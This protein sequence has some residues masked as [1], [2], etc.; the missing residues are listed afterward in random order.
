MQEW[1]GALTTGIGMGSVWG[2]WHVP[3][4]IQNDQAPAY[5]AV[6]LLAAVGARILIVWLYNNA[7]K[8]VLAAILFHVMANVSSSFVATAAAGP[9]IAFMAVIVTVLWGSKTLAW[10]RY[11]S[12]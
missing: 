10:Y 11:T 12:P 1:W 6:G 2:A 4:L 9:I 3:A 5:L 7:G 8:S